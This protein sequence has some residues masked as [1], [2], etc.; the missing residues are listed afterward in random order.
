MFILSL[1]KVA[2]YINVQHI[3]CVR[4]K[5]SLQLLIKNFLH[6]THFPSLK[7]LAQFPTY[8]INSTQNRLKKDILNYSS[9]DI[10]K[11]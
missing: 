7:M 4:T 9:N 1:K 5:T 11:Y 10:H 8:N 2:S 3:K 6:M